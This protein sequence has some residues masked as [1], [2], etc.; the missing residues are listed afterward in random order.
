MRRLRQVGAEMNYRTRTRILGFL[1]LPAIFAML[2]GCAGPSQDSAPAQDSTASAR[3][4]APV[5][6]STAVVEPTVAPHG[7]PA[8]PDV[9]PPAAAPVVRWVPIGPIGPNDPQEGRMYLYAQGKDCDKLR[10][11]V[12]GTTFK[13]VWLA[14]AAVCDALRANTGRSWQ[15]AAAATAAM[16]GVPP[17]RCLELA[18]AAVVRGVVEYHA[19]NPTSAVPLQPGVG[20][21]CPRHLSGLTVVDDN[22]KPVPGLQRPS[23]PRTGGTW[24]RLDG[25]YVRVGSLKIDGVDSGVETRSAGDY[26][27]V[28]F[29]T[30]A[31]TTKNSFTV[32]I[33][34]TLEVDGVVQFFYDDTVGSSGGSTAGPSST[35]G[36]PKPSPSGTASP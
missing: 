22:L 30:P 28:Y 15:A 34:D 4:R 1:L 10:D 26:S 17:N 8:G 18:I 36:P 7:G 27:P 29:K 24:V 11:G 32:T 25:Y 13:D 35:A 16:P 21:S 20:E 19:S 12:D 6:A 23:G 33:T 9:P 2:G 3:S 31:A 5:S 14:A